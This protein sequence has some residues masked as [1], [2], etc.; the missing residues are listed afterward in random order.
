MSEKLVACNI[1]RLTLDAESIWGGNQRKKKVNPYFISPE[2]G[3]SET[4][5][6]VEFYSNILHFM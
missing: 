4:F 2:V 6:K 3:S 1:R 5:L